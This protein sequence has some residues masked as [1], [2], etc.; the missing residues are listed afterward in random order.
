MRTRIREIRKAKGMTLAQVAARVRPRPTTAQ[1]VGR[2][3]TGRRRL[4]LE[5]LHK[6]ADALEVA[7]AD[8]VI[9]PAQP[10]CPL[11]A[12]LTPDALKAPAFAEMIDLRLAARDPVAVRVAAGL[13]AWRAG[14]VIILERVQGSNLAALVGEDVLLEARPGVLLYGRLIDGGPD[15]GLMLAAATRDKTLHRHLAPVWGGR[16]VMLLRTLQ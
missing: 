8:L 7:P 5:W 6:L 3:E 1:T 16:P 10:H 13:G 4:S 15:G 12:I 9:L 14:D 11:L 2:L